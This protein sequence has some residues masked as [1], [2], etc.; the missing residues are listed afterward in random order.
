[1]CDS[2]SVCQI[3]CQCGRAGCVSLVCVSVSQCGASLVSECQCQCPSACMRACVCVCE[4]ERERE[5]IKEKL[6]A[7]LLDMIFRAKFRRHDSTI[8]SSLTLNY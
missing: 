4:R 5:K 7:G 2:S 8:A 3:E 6:K 1:M